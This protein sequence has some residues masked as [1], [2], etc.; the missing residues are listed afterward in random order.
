MAKTNSAPLDPVGLHNIAGDQINPATNEKLDELK[1]LLT[2]I[3]D[4]VDDLEIKADTINLNT[5]ELEGKLDS[6]I[7]NTKR[8]DTATLFNVSQ[9]DT[10]VTLLVANSSRVGAIIVNDSNADLYIKFGTTASLNSFTVKLEKNDYY[11]LPFKYTGRIDA[12]WDSSG[13]GVARITELT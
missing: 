11:E 7:D 1:A 13:S 2:L 5:D 6:V 10:S 8:S 9:S 12:I 4:A 3:E